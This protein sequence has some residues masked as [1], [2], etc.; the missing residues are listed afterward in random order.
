MITSKQILE[1]FS[2][3]LDVM[4]GYTDIFVNPSSSDYAEIYK[5]SKYHW[6]KFIADNKTKVVYVWNAD[7]GIHREIVTKLNLVNRMKDD[8]ILAGDAGLSNGKATM[9]DSDLLTSLFEGAKRGNKDS[10]ASLKMLLSINWNWVENYISC[11]NW[12]IGFTG[13]VEKTIKTP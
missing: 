3:T 8:D 4:G 11:H 1:I 7:K 6:V 13:M 9:Q 2:K 5:E 10:E 12:L